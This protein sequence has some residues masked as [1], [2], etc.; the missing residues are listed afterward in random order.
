M[1]RKF[2]LDICHATGDWSMK[3]FLVTT[4]ERLKMEIGEERI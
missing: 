2:L 4:V 3:D 1:I